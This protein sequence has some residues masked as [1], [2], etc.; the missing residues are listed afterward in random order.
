MLLLQV[1]NK[2]DSLFKIVG[3]A[4]VAAKVTRDEC[5]ENWLFEEDGES[6]TIP[7]ALD[8]MGRKAAE[9]NAHGPEQSRDTRDS[10]GEQSELVPSP[11]GNILGSGY[12]GG[13]TEIPF[14]AIT[15]LNRTFRSQDCCLDGLLPR[16]RLRISLCGPVLMEYYQEPIGSESLYRQMVGYGQISTSPQHFMWITR[17]DE[18]QA[19]LVKAFQSGQ[20]RE[21][22]RCAVTKD[23]SLCTL[24]ML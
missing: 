13:R 7:R 22:D 23:L 3:A 21:K 19:S 10:L 16:S 6:T 20:G 9:A 15:T 14:Q 18:G 12:P 11:W 8:D 24:G 5:I 2:A 1:R 4:S 17:V